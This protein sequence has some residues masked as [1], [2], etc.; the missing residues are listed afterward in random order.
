MSRVVIVLPVKESHYAKQRLSPVLHPWER[1]ALWWTMFED[2]AEAL[3]ATRLPVAVVTGSRRA[4]AR[5]EQSAWRVI[6]EHAQVSE[7][8]SVD[9]A[10]RLLAAESWPC[11]LRIPAD[12]PLVRPEDIT[13]LADMV[14]NPGPVLLLPSLD[15]T[16]T[17]AIRRSPPDLF[18]S[19]FGPNSLVLHTH[20]ALRAGYE[21]AMVRN[22]RIALDLDDTSDVGLFL[23]RPS[24]TRTFDLL[25]KLGIN[26]RIALSASDQYQYT[27]A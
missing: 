2:V 22:E 5:A 6:W 14:S 8:A 12:I 23:D 19:R 11:A 21:P 17:N 9:F 20:E 24:G 25:S 27:R 26:E 1:E 18:P 4:A 16:G 3:Q 13:S 15:G 10:C 7:S